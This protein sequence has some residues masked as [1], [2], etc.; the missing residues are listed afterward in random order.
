M[1]LASLLLSEIRDQLQDTDPAAYRWTDATLLRYMSSAQR[2][3]VS[4]RAD[5]N[6]I[7]LLHTIADATPR[8]LLPADAV[9]LVTAVANVEPGTSARTTT[10]Q[11]TQLDVLDAVDPEWRF[12]APTLPDPARYFSAYAHDPA[13]PR[14]FWLYPRPADGTRVY[15][16]YAQLPPVIATAGDALTLGDRYNAPVIEYTLWRALSTEGRY[17]RPGDTAKVHLDTF[18]QL[19]GLSA[20]EY[21]GVVKATHQRDKSE[22]A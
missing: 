15:V 17:A 18:A 7:E 13:E 22:D 10:V 3:I 16:T 5:A 11:R 2:L 19:L 1:A 12:T 20:A 21:K 14:V 4:L 6:T 8:R 9:S